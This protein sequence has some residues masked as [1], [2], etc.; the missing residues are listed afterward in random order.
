M[1][2]TDSREMDRKRNLLFPTPVPARVPGQDMAEAKA[3]S[4]YIPCNQRSLIHFTHGISH[5]CSQR[6]HLHMEGDLKEHVTVAQGQ[7]TTQLQSTRGMSKGDGNEEM[8]D[9][10]VTASKCQTCTADSWHWEFGIGIQTADVEDEHHRAGRYLYP[11]CQN[12]VIRVPDS[13]HKTLNTYLC[14]KS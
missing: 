5:L 10:L 7:T 11:N 3:F 12:T 4:S 2:L 1:R 13:L 8:F 6:Q 14:P 9:A